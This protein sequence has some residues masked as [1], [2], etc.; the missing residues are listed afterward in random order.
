[1][2][3]GQLLDVSISQQLTAFCDGHQ[4]ST[5]ESCGL[6]INFVSR[7]SHSSSS[8]EKIQI[9]SRAQAESKWAPRSGQRLVFRLAPQGPSPATCET[10]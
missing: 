6:S 9:I 5:G 4:V 10:E 2:I 8:G 7:Q 3:D 1:M